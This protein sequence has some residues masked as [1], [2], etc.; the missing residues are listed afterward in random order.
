MSDGYIYCFS[1]NSLCDGLLKIGMTSRTPEERL[2]DANTDTWIPAPFKIEF[3][4]KVKNALKIEK[5]IHAIL[6]EYRIKGKEFFRV[7]IEHVREIFDIIDGE[8]WTESTDSVIKHITT[9]S[10]LSSSMLLRWVCYELQNGTLPNNVSTRNLYNRFKEWVIKESESEYETD[11]SETLFGKLLSEKIKSIDGS[12][13]DLTTVRK[14]GGLML[15]TFNIP[16]LI[17]ELIRLKL[18][19]KDDMTFNY[20]DY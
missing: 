1:N 7:S 2:S 17:E 11:P 18:L 8:V 9:S 10:R 19:N 5:A 16:T 14:S 4:K 6:A 13:F 3:A 15:R 20:K 12:L